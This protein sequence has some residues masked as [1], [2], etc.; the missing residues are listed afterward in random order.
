MRCVKA[1]GLLL[2]LTCLKGILSEAKGKIDITCDALADNHVDWDCILGPDSLEEVHERGGTFTSCRYK[3]SKHPCSRFI[4]KKEAERSEV[5][6]Q[7]GPSGFPFKK[8]E[9]YVFKYSFRAVESMKVATRFTHLGQIK[10]SKGGYMIKGD[11]IYSLTA[12]KYGLMVRFSNKDTIEDFHPGLEKYLN[13]EDATG[14]WVDVKI[15]TVFGRSMEVEISGAVKGKAVW[16]S[17]LGPVAWHRDAEM[18]RLKLGLY[19]SKD[20]VADGEVEFRKISIEGPNGIIRTSPKEDDEDDDDDA[21]GDGVS[22]PVSAETKTLVVAVNDD[23]VYSV[24][25]GVRVSRGRGGGGIGGGKEN[26][27]GA[28]ERA[29]ERSPEWGGEAGRRERGGEESRGGARKDETGRERGGK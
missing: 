13:W 9:R 7:Q 19:H 22:A 27:R 18:A 1:A 17:K 12:N 3:R 4:V 25:R 29:G 5:K 20:N 16:P 8:N 6:V 10:G 15:T 23:N 28:V 26:Q 24:G 14:E 21:G 2:A 11:P